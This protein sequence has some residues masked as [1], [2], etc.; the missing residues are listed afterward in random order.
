MLV[1]CGFVGDRPNRPSTAPS[2]KGTPYER[3]AACVRDLPIWIVHGEADAAVPV[4]ESRL[5]QDALRA[6]SADVRYAELP[7]TG[8]DAWTPTYAS[9]AI[10]EWLFAQR[11]RGV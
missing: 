3:T 11:R 4:T 9:Q 6:L 2:G 10:V 1:I 7:G 8:H 5:M